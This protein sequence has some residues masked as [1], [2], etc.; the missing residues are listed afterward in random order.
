LPTDPAVIDMVMQAL[1]SAPLARPT[2]AACG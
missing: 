1:G 2:A